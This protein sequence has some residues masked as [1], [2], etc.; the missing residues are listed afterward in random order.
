MKDSGI[1]SLVMLD[2]FLLAATIEVY[3]P[4]YSQVSGMS[5]TL[6]SCLASD[7]HPLSFHYKTEWSIIAWYV[8]IYIHYPRATDLKPWKN[9]TLDSRER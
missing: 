9:Y 3:T 7:A 4:L 6:F 2:S 8:S 1:I 5:K